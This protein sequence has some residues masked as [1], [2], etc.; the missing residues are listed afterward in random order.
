MYNFYFE[1]KGKEFGPFEAMSEQSARITLETEYAWM[2][3]DSSATLSKQIPSEGFEMN[4][5]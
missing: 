2:G 4:L 5:N 1:Y 3:V